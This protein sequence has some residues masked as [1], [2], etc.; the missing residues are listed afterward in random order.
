MDLRVVILARIQIVLA[1]F[2]AR[3]L[4]SSTIDDITLISENRHL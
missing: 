1:F 3:T 4:D 2:D